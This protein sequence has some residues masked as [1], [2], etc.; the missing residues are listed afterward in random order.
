MNTDLHL[1]PAES[2][3]SGGIFY[4]GY[5]ILQ[6]PSGIL[7]EKY[8]ANKLIM[9]FSIAWGLV[10]VATGSC[11]MALNFWHFVSCSG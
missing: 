3:L 5:I 6:I 1:G 7:V 9:L 11:R 8:D 2:G 10:A 4:L